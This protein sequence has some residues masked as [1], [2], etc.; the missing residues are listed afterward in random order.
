VYF[1]EYMGPRTGEAQMEAY[2]ASVVD[3]T[4]WSVVSP[5]NA[6]AMSPNLMAF[7]TVTAPVPEPESYAMMLAGLGLVSVIARRR[8]RY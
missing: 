5:A 3:V 1:A 7:Q 8:L 4:K 2:R 6:T